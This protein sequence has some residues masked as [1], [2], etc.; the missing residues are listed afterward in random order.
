MSTIL[1]TQPQGLDHATPAGHPER[2]DRLRR[3]NKVFALPQFADIQTKEAAC[4]GLDFALEVHPKEYVEKIKSLRPV[5]G[6]SPIDGDTYISKESLGAVMTG[7]GA[8]LGAL[9]DVLAGNFDN[10]FCAIRPPGH[11]AERLAPMGFCLF[12]TIA[13][14]ARIAQQKGFERVAIVDFDVHHGN[15]TQDIFYTDPNVLYASSHQ[16]PLFPGTGALNETGVGNIFNAPLS[17]D[18]DGNEMRLAYNDVLL[19]AIDNFNP[20]IILI[21]AGF[22]ADKRDPMA[23]LN[24]GPNDFA[25]I[26]GKLM[27]IAG[28][29]CNNRIISLLEGGYDL[30]GLGQGV[31]AHLSML[32]HGVN[33]PAIDHINFKHEE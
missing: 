17:E 6:M 27:D 14:V 2:A 3:L 23:G 28:K 29:R 32:A 10:A 30:D 31:A 26:T 7:M 5:E 9:D 4:A 20:D 13:I 16:M 11:H 12:N 15:G 18:T 21:S 25:W 8:G 19:P 33:G 1:I 22:D 24:W